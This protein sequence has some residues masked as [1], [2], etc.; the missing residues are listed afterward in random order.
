MKLFKNIITGVLLVSTLVIN[1]QGAPKVHDFNAK[2]NVGIIRYDEEIACKKL[3]IKKKEKIAEVS[4]YIIKFNRAID[5]LKFRHFIVLNDTELM[6]NVR[7]KVIIANRDFQAM[8]E[9][10]IET[11]EKLRPIKKEVAELSIALMDGLKSVLSDKQFKKWKKYA[12]SV[13]KELLPVVEKQER[14]MMNSRSSMQGMN[15][16]RGM[17]RGMGRRRY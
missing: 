6:V 16:G 2:N 3:K 8:T 5:E 4:K 13:R 10:Q 12:I 11:H 17:G 15:R 9:L 14:P 7:Q 1:A